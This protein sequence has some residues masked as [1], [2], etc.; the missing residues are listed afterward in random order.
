MI[1][2]LAA[3]AINNCVIL[4]HSECR[5]TIFFPAEKIN[6][7]QTATLFFWTFT[8]DKKTYFYIQPFD[9]LLSIALAG[10][11]SSRSKQ[12]LLLYQS[13]TYI[14]SIIQK[15]KSFNLFVSKKA[16]NSIF[17]SHNHWYI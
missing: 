16:H 14:I 5:S 2:S 12:P 3:D 9:S 15:L 10:N 7:P 6:F 17:L 13:T 8:M 4:N 11:L 1:L